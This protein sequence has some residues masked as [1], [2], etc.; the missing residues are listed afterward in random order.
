MMSPLTKMERRKNGNPTTLKKTKA[1]STRSSMRS[2]QKMAIKFGKE[3]RSL[4]APLAVLTLLTLHCQQAQAT[5]LPDPLKE[6]LKVTFPQS[7]IRLDGVVQ[8]KDGSLF[9]PLIPK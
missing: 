1:C 9:L 2:V 3:R 8:T 5:R 6:A 7:N 4:L